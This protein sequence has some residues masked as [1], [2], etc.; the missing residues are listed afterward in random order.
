MEGLQST[1]ITN[2]LAEHLRRG[3]LLDLAPDLALGSPADEA[4]MMSWDG[5][6]SIA[7]N[8]IRELLRGRIV[9][10]PDPRGCACALPASAVG[11]TWTT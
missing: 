6:H 10:D 1:S 7:A 2:K 9:T 4:V 5:T 8:D 3:E 11:L